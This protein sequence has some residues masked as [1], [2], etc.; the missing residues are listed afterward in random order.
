M[1]LETSGRFRVLSSPRERDELLLIDREEFD[2]VYVGTEGYPDALGEAVA[3]LRPGYLIDAALRWPEE[4]DPR[5]ADLSVERRD[6]LVFA[7]GV[8]GIFEAAKETWYTAEAEG[9]GM[10]SR[11]TRDTDGEPNGVLY[12]FAEQAGARDLFEEFRSGV[13]PLEP[14]LQRVEAGTDDD[15][16]RTVFVLRPADEPFLVVYI[17]FRQAGL[18]DRRMRDTY[19]LHD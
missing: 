4:G 5:F 15:G 18:P 19:A 17:V 14:L 3:D 12:V 1:E 16:A 6:E 8:T 10:N 9:E 11:V 13:R 7:D 2:P